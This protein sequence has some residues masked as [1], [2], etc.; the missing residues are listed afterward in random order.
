MTQDPPAVSLS[1]SPFRV[2]RAT[3]ADA[4]S[5]AEFNRRLAQETEDTILDPVVLARGVDAVLADESKGLY[6]VAEAGDAIVGQVMVTYEWSDWRNGPLWWLQSVYVDAAWR[7]R[8]VFRALFTRV[9][10]AAKRA[11]VV[12]FRL[13]V[14]QE[15]KAAQEVYE[16]VGLQR[17]RYWVMERPPD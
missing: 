4:S 13:Y 8:G 3:P 11:G 10:E 17:S 12:G 16:R 9:L 15:N 1:D 5:V 14:E 2:R 7:R 6:F